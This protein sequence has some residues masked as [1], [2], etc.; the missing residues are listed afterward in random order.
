MNEHDDIARELHAMRAEP[1]PEYARELDQ[2]AAEWLRKGR[3]RSRF[4]H[5]R[6]LLPA[7]AAAAAAGAVVLALVLSDGGDERTELQVAVVPDQGEVEAL[8]GGGSGAAEDSGAA[9]GEAL[10]R[11]APDQPAEGAFSV[12]KAD[13]VEPGEPVVL[14][15]FFTAS[16]E[17]TIEL[18]GREATVKVGPGSGRVEV[19]TEGLPVG[20][21][22]LELAFPPMPPV[23]ER[24]EIGD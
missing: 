5:P 15:Y 11:A 17:G 14:R 22:R 7:A 21:Q 9:E 2:R 19:S 23:R 6:L 13:Q 12:A 24:I 8:G 18:A 16:V 3:G 10:S 1:R 4:L 20:S